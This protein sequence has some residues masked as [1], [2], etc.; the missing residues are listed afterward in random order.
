MRYRFL[1][2]EIDKDAFAL[3]R[4]GRSIPVEPR[5]LDFLVYLIEHRKR[6]VPT[7][8]LVERVW[9]GTEI[10]PSAI[11]RCV[12]LARAVLGQPGAI[13]TIYGR[14]HQWVAPVRRYGG[15]APSGPQ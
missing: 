8:E 5:V 14:G 13:R 12:C 3:R 15:I 6:M 2:F 10:G 1:E 4:E 9:G 7:S 11:S